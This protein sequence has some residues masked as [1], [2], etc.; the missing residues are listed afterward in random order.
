MTFKDLILPPSLPP[1]LGRARGRAKGRGKNELP[2]IDIYY[3]V[4]FIIVQIPNL[5]EF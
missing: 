4:G 3:R 2:D 1:P 5:D